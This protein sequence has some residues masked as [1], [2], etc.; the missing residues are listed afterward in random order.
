MSSDNIVK[1]T[2]CK[3]EFPFSVGI[4]ELHCICGHT[5]FFGKLSKGAKEEV[6]GLYNKTFGD[7]N[8]IQHNN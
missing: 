7:N 2:G 1:C 5:T 6:V 4:E 3:R 8:E